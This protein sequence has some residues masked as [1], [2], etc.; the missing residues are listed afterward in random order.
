MTTEWLKRIDADA[1]LR[2]RLLPYC[3]QRH[4]HYWQDSISGDCAVSVSGNWRVTF[5]F[6]DGHAVEVD[7]TDYH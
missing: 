6:E 4:G 7:Y 3:R 5:K 1:K 2:K